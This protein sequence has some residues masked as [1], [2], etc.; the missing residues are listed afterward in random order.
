MATALPGENF[1]EAKVVSGSSSPVYTVPAGRYAYVNIL[2][3]SVSDPFGTNANISGGGFSAN[4]GSSN[5]LSL[6]DLAQDNNTTGTNTLTAA[7][8]TFIMVE[9]QSFSF[10]VSGN[11]SIFV[12]EFVLS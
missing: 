1:L 5:S 9:G 6:G 3:F 7:A 10:N 4:S 12:R 8:S 11:A 2:G